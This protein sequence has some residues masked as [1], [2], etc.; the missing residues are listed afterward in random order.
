LKAASPSRRR[1]N[2]PPRPYD[3]QQR[4]QVTEEER[5]ERKK[6]QNKTAATRYRRKK[7]EEQEGNCMDLDV[8]ES[9]NK[10]LKDRV[11]TLTREVSYLRHLMQEVLKYK[12]ASN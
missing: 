5:R 8:L 7:K 9:R 4:R 2:R 11:S 1:Q 6:E 12:R 10:S 3:K